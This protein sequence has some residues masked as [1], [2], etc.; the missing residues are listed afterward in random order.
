[1]A[2]RTVGVK[3]QA[4]VSGYMAGLRQAGAAT[5]GLVGEMDK[6][7]KAG[8]LDEVANQAA[9][10]GLGLVA[11]AGLAT[12]FAMDFEK[13]MSAVGA[14]TGATAADMERL[15]QAALQAG[16]D[17]KYSATEAAQGIEELSKAGVSTSAILSGGLAGAL[18]LAAAGNLDVAEAAETAASAM[19]QFKL[20]GS[21]VPHIAD[22]LAAAAGKAQGSVHDMGFA[23]SQAGLVSAQMGMSIEDTTG[24][25]AAFASA[26]LLGSDSGTSLKT[27]LLMLAN[28]TEKSAD[29]MA[30]L[31]I[32]VYDAQGK[33][34]G[35]TSLAG[36]L[37]T[38]LGGL[39][40]Q[41]RNAALAT[42]FGSD[43]IRAASVL[44]EQ[45]SKGIQGWITKVNDQGYAAETAAKKTDNLAGDIER[46]T[47]SLE[48]LAIESAQ[49]STSGMRT[50]VQAADRLVNSLGAIP[51]PVQNAGVVIAAVGGAALLAA[52][53]AAKLRTSSAA[54]LTSLA[55]M[56]PTGTRAAKGLER[57]AQWAGRAAIALAAVQTASALLGEST[58]AQIAPLAKGLA[59]FGAGADAAGEASRL[60]GDDLGTLRYDLG[61]LDDGFW[62]GLGN[63]VAGFVE[64]MTGLG[65]VMDE[66]MTHAKERISAVDAALAQLVQSGKSAQ[67]GD[68]FNRLAVE[69]GKSGVSVERLK[70]ALPQYAAALDSA[71]SSATSAAGATGEGASALSGMS[72]KAEEAEK[73]LQELNDAFDELFDTQMSIDEALLKS[74]QSVDD[75]TDSFAKNGSEIDRDTEK[76]RA[77]RQAI[78]DR[79][80]SIKDERDARIAHGETLDEA[81]AKYVKDIDGL[82]RSMKAAGFTKKEIEALTGAYRKIPDDVETKV[83]TT[84]T[85]PAMTK[86]QELYLLQ[87]TLAAGKPMAQIR[88]DL[89]KDN[90]DFLKYA[91]G[92]SVR[93]YSPHARADNI[94]ALLTA[95]E[96]VQPVGAVDYYGVAAMEAIRTRRIPAEELRA[97]A[98]FADGGLVGMPKVGRQ[99]P[100]TTTAAMTR[101]PSREQVLSVVAP[102][103]PTSGATGP[104]IV[105]AVR[106]A[107]PELRAISTYRPGAT[108]LTGNRSY[109][110]LNRAVDYPPSRALAEWW[111]RNYMSRTKEL[112][113]PWNE[114]NIHNGRRHTYTGAVWNQHN[115]AGGNAHDHIAMSDGGVINEPVWGVGMASGRTYSL[116]ERG[117]ETVVPGVGAMAGGTVVQVIEHR[118]TIVLEGTGVLR[119]FQKEIRNG[120]GDVQ[121]RLGP[122]KR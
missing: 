24:T 55:E 89:S 28:P 94:P 119:G 111:N 83:K 31:G 115:F 60:F 101:I 108:T 22:L 75:L 65:N 71:A 88:K 58:N 110:A 29:L 121:S 78:L 80:D 62:A 32:N 49:G 96:F 11:T 37:Q 66:S 90:A 114:L 95:R 12:K 38:Q 7:A 85:G 84:G 73:Q 20:A 13:Q 26:G 97:L 106:A 56:G 81:N 40:Q 93:G 105:A 100:F 103:I 116:G 59:E 18:D 30:E 53:G 69:A 45:G 113:T 16:A 122:R 21:D 51:A 41:Q 4:E 46:L 33:F 6:A 118:H 43:A 82:R 47:G 87:R 17:T 5:R 44:Y 74:A 77:N 79:I 23:L 2:L 68:A 72:Q 1:M 64:G 76:G 9:G 99:W 27:A 48:T 15:R 91:D 34:V 117:P 70:G 67:A 120:G 42:I 61:T 107:F 54:A 104:A 102:G 112:I 92:G 36:Q 19:T 25:L 3:L 57:A 14:A 35:I 50:L 63:G 98:Q 10:L 52:A 39:T 8:R 109:H 86:L